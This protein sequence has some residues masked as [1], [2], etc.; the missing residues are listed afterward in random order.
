LLDSVF[1]NLSCIILPSVPPPILFYIW[2]WIRRP[3]FDIW[4]WTRHAWSVQT[5]STHVPILLFTLITHVRRITRIMCTAHAHRLS[6]NETQHSQK[7]CQNT[8]S[9]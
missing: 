3:F 7:N 1:F 9:S 8:F 4:W 6:T 2:W 5:C